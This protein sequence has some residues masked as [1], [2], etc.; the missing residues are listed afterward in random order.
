V[1]IFMK[2]RRETGPEQCFFELSLIE[3]LA[4]KRWEWW[5]ESVWFAR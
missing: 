3:D 4:R 5:A 1:P 2:S